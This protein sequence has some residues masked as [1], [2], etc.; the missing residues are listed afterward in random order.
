MYSTALKPCLEVEWVVHVAYVVAR[1]VTVQYYVN[2]IGSVQG[3]PRGQYC[4]IF[5]LGLILC[6]AVVGTRRRAEVLKFE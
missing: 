5:S 1:S 3:V 6:V 2:E 4:T